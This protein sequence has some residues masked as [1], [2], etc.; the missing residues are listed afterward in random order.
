MINEIILGLYR[1][2]M[3]YSFK[4]DLNLSCTTLG[5]GVRQEA[6]YVLN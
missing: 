5:E 3:A 4:I 6:N 2:V 1:Y